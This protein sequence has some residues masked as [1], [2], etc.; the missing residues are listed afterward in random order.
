MRVP[1][2]YDVLDEQRLHDGRHQLALHAERIEL[3]QNFGCSHT[4]QHTTPRLIAELKQ[5]GIV[6]EGDV[7]GSP[8]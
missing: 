5:A 8:N 7:V 4:F 1:T 6:T 2:V 3:D